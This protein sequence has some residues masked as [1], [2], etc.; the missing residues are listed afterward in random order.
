MGADLSK[1]KP[2]ITAG[3]VQELIQNQINPE[4][5]RTVSTK[6]HLYQDHEIKKWT[7][8]MKEKIHPSLNDVALEAYVRKPPKAAIG[9]ITGDI[10]SPEKPFQQNYCTRNFFLDNKG[11]IWIIDIMHDRYFYP[12]NISTYE[13]VLI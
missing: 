3:S 12:M 8:E 10:R 6:Y 2:S 5:I 11:R 7:R 9:Y 4:N 13:K 1:K